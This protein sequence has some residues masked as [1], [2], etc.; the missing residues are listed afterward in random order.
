MLSELHHPA[1]HY[2]T[3]ATGMRLIMNTY[4][5]NINRIE[6][7]VTMACTGKCKHCSEGDHTNCTGHIDA[8]VA[9]KAVRDLCEN[10]KIESL[11]T[12]GGEPL[13][14]PE[15]VCAIHR[16][17]ADMGIPKRDLIT[18]GFFSKDFRKIK[19]VVQNLLHVINHYQVYVKQRRMLLFL[20]KN[21]LII[22]L[23]IVILIRQNKKIVMILTDL[24]MQ[25]DLV[26]LMNMT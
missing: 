15:V 19:Q 8:D 16:T 17:A 12:F 3:S 4:V 2:H 1:E 18:N 10:Y 20:S 11:M 25:V 13:L 5:K 24:L 7:V 22:F 6:F 23:I 21:Y 9:T 26:H 14:Y